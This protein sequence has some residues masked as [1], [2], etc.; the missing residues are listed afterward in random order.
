MFPPSQL[1]LNWTIGT[2]H[3][4]IVEHSSLVIV[5]VYVDDILVSGPNKSEIH[6]VQLFLKR[7]LNLK[8]PEDL[9]YFLG[10]E[11]TKLTKNCQWNTI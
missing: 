3:T 5:L 9:R 2:D 8:I 7:H 10:L 1:V 11:I 6:K 4:S